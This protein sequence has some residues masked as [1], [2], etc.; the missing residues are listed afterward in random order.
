M[1]LGFQRDDALDRLHAEPVARALV[2]RCELLDLGSLCEGH[3]VLIGRENLARIFFSGLLDECEEA[4]GTLLAV[5]DKRAAEDLV[6]AVLRVDLCEAEDLGVGQRASVLLF[7][8]MEIF[9]FLRTQRE[10]LLLVVLLDVVD[11]LD[12][13]RLVVD[14]EDSLVQTFVHTLEHGIVLGVLAFDGEVLLN[15]R[16]AGET[17][18]LRDLNGIC[19]PWCNHFAAWSDEEAVQLLVAEHLG[20]AVEPAQ[21]LLL[22]LTGLVVHLSGNDSLLRSLKEKN[23]SLSKVLYERCVILQVQR[24]KKFSINRNVSFTFC[25]CSM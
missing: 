9:Y 4:R 17:H 20:V 8:L 7:Y 15:T 16:N 11:V 22:L 3:V 5:D 13:L 14:G 18:V 23:H 25:C 19:A 6:T 1:S 12:G 2:F 21:F 10:A 24:Y